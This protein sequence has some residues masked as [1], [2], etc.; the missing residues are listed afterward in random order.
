MSADLLIPEL[1][2]TTVQSRSRQTRI[3]TQNK[4]VLTVEFTR[5]PLSRRGEIQIGLPV[6]PHQHIDARNLREV[7]LMHTQAAGGSTPVPRRP[8]SSISNCTPRAGRREPFT[9]D[10]SPAYGAPASSKVSS[11]RWLVI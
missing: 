1:L 8:V 2:C 11:P 3:K 6:R 9:S 4:I 5:I 7:T 10:S